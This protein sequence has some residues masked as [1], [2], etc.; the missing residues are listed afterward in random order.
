MNNNFRKL[1]FYESSKSPVIYYLFSVYN[2][3][4]SAAHFERHLLWQQMVGFLT[5]KNSYVWSCFLIQNAGHC[6]ECYIS[7]SNNG[8]HWNTNPCPNCL[9]YVR[10]CRAIHTP[11]SCQAF[12]ERKGCYIRCWDR[13]PILYNWY[14]RCSPL[15]RKW[16]HPLFFTNELF[17]GTKNL[18]K[19]ACRD[20]YMSQS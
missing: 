15:C 10:G 7:S 5:I 6:D 2:I 16:V 3:L 20:V 8:E 17:F 11:K 9:P 4:C 1:Q 12:R 13:E 18:D 14:S 19:Y